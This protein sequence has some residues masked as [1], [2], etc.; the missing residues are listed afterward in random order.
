MKEIQVIRWQVLHIPNT[1]PIS[2]M[3]DI[4]HWC[5]KP[6]FDSQRTEQSRFRG[7]NI[8]PESSCQN[9]LVSWETS[10]IQQAKNIILFPKDTAL[11]YI[12]RGLQLL[13][14]HTCKW[15]GNLLQ[16]LWLS[17]KPKETL[18]YEYFYKM[19]LGHLCVSVS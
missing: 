4:S 13:F 18:D 2:D 15:L 6:Q 19:L 12:I 3:Q 16:S 14:K 17:Y 10:P 5:L 7:W 9:V 1:I 8:G 11:R